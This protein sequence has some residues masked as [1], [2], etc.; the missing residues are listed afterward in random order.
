MC[1]YI[2]IFIYLKRLLLY[3]RS[4]YMVG[5]R[6]SSNLF[7][8]AKIIIRAIMSLALTLLCGHLQALTCFLRLFLSIPQYLAYCLLVHG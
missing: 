6:I 7:F 5:I 8:K 1:V 4:V 2:Y 3:F